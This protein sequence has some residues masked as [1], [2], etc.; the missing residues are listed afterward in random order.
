[1]AGTVP[2]AGTIGWD[3]QTEN[4]IF[5]KAKTPLNIKNLPDMETLQLK[6]SLHEL[7]ECIA[8]K[9]MLEAVHAILNQSRLASAEAD[10]TLDPW[11]KAL[12]EEAIAECDANP[13]GGESWET[14]K[15]RILASRR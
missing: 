6:R 9:R 14:V 15:T 12:L 3:T 10:F 7:I 5:A 2:S 11:Q 13:D 8:D 4:G 1:M